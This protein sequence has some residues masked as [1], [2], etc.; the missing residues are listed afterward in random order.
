V[1][2][3][4]LLIGTKPVLGRQAFGLFGSA[5]GGI[6]HF[7]DRLR[8]TI[9]IVNRARPLGGEDLAPRVTQYAETTQITLGRGKSWPSFSR[10]RVKAFDSM[11]FLG[12]PW[13]TKRAG[14]FGRG[15]WLGLV[16]G[17]KSVILTG[18]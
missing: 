7:V 4:P 11:A 18:I 17:M 12:E 15:V 1:I 2:E 9:E 16:M 3:S 5:G 10:T 14:I 6:L 13:P 8:K